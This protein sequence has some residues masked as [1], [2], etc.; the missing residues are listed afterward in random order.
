MENIALFFHLLGAFFVVSGTV[1]AGVAFGAG[2]RRKTP[3]EIALLLGLARIGV[4]LVVPGV[5]LAVGFGLWLVGLGHWGYN[6]GWVGGALG[7]RMVTTLLGVVG[8]QVPKQARRI[9]SQLAAEGR[10][11]SAEPRAL[12]DDRASLAINYISALL[13]LAIIVLMVWKPGAAHS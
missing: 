9:A 11:V 12:L 10:P 2:R 7:L 1:V 8:G 3:A 6:A 13:L 5:L 4:A